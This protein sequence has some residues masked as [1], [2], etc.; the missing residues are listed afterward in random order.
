MTKIK[1]KFTLLGDLVKE[2]RD[3]KT[4]ITKL[5]KF[6]ESQH[7][8]ELSVENQELLQEQLEYMSRYLGVLEKRFELNK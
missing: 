6:K 7:F 2:I 3:L 5:V 8:E 1:D 4:K